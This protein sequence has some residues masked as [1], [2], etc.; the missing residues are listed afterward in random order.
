MVFKVSESDQVTVKNWFANSYNYIEQVQ[1]ADGTRWDVT[2]L[3]A[4]VLTDL[5]GTESADTLNGTASSDNIIGLAGDD[6]LN[7]LA[8]ND[9]LDGGA[10]SDIMAGGS[11]NDIYVLGRDYGADT[12]QE[13]DATAGNTDILQ[14]Q[15]GIASDQIWLRQA[16][17]NLEVSIIG[18]TDKATLTNWYL[19]S[20][21]HVEQFKTSDGKILLDSQVQNLVSAMAAFAPPAAGQTTLAANYAA[22]LEPVMAANWQ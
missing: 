5:N 20:Q 21:Y 7:G 13:N 15:G 11:G 16:S 19:G 2:T 17:N 4:N 12:V 1:F 18:T 10:G 22:A 14:F 8:G 3:Q 9:R 6:I